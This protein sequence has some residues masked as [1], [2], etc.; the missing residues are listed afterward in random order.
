MR[1]GAGSLASLA[2]RERQGGSG[3]AR[4]CL[5]LQAAAELTPVKPGL[6]DRGGTV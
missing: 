4:A 1:A 6:A 3:K 5:H 2:G